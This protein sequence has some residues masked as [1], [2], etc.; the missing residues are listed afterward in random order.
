MQAN[1]KAMRYERLCKAEDEDQHEMD[2]FCSVHQKKTRAADR[3]YGRCRDEALPN[4][5]T[6]HFLANTQKR[7]LEKIERRP[8]G[9]S[10]SR[11]QR[12]KHENV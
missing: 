4:A 11:K 3:Y 2:H 5:K 1:D 12:S 8:L 9:K 10:P 7:R 6:K